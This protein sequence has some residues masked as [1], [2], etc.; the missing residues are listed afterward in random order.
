MQT[1]V[2]RNTYIKENEPKKKIVIIKKKNIVS[3]MIFAAMTIVAFIQ[4]FPLVWVLDFSFSKDTD[5]FGSSIL[6]IPNPIQWRNYVTAFVDG[7]VLQYA[8]NSLVVC[9]LTISI[10]VL[11]SLTLGYAFTRMEWKLRGFFMS[12]I[13]LG[14]MVPIHATLLPNFL[15]YS[16]IHILNT[17]LAL[18]LP[19]I[20]FALPTG[21]FIMSGFLE[22]IPKSLEESA[23]M[24]G[25]GVYRTIFSIIL[26]VTKPAIVTVTVMTFLSVWNEFILANTYLSTTTFR[27]LPFSVF[28]FSSKYVS[29]YSVQFAVMV[30]TA[31]PA[32]A[33][34]I[35]LN[36]HITKGVTMGAVKG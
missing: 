33:V 23:F 8:L 14:M 25:C 13:L 6:T 21:V 3:W 32:I 24:D 15:V 34:Y 11:L 19:Y 5:L 26:P 20:A 31:I 36:E 1:T 17:Y 18:L 4:F 10:T 30:I 35:V 28:E 2:N 22:S 29:Q 7:H 9:S 12:I 27:T 16:K